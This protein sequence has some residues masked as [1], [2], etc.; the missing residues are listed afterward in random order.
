MICTSFLMLNGSW[1]TPLW[2]SMKMI[3]CLKHHELR[4]DFGFDTFSNLWLQ[5]AYRSWNLDCWWNLIQSGWLLQFKHARRPY[6][7]RLISNAFVSSSFAYLSK[8]IKIVKHAPFDLEQKKNFWDW[9]RIA[10]F[11][12]S[13]CS[14]VIQSWG[15]NKESGFDG[16]FFFELPCYLQTSVF[17][18]MYK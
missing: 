15:V 10:V 8:N 14:A 11:F 6:S 5:P 4:L 17:V 18:I 7:L 16:F 3:N 1:K 13:Y 12:Y 9:H 2:F